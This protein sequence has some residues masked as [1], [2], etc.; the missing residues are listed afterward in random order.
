MS[1]QHFVNPNSNSNFWK[2]H[3]KQGKPN[4]NSNFGNSHDKQTKHDK[5]LNKFLKKGEESKYH[6]KLALQY[7]REQKFDEA[8]ME[9]GIARDTNSDPNMEKVFIFQIG[10]IY[11]MSRDYKKAIENFNSAE[12]MGFSEGESCFERGKAYWRN[13]QPH[14]AIADFIKAIPAKKGLACF[15]IGKVLSELGEYNEALAAFETAKEMGF[16]KPELEIEIRLVTRR[17]NFK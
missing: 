17:A 13:R 9:L 2:L 4:N 12:K 16:C 11:V 14:E 15:H 5:Q 7:S 3:E 8:L 1:N 6:Y 10:M